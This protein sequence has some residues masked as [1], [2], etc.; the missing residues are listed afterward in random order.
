MVRYH[1]GS[2][3]MGPGRPSP[4]RLWPADHRL[5]VRTLSMRRAACVCCAT[6][7]LAA[8]LHGQERLARR[9]PSIQLLQSEAGSVAPEFEADVLIRL[10]QLPKVDKVWRTEM[11]DMAYMRAYA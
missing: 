7:V 8:G 1:T 2:N 6:I 10:S 4:R 5:T 9:D 11:L 3:T